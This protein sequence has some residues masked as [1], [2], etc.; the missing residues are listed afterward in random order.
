MWPAKTPQRITK[1]RMTR[2][3][4]ARRG[5][6]KRPRAYAHW[7]RAVRSRPDSYDSSESLSSGARSV[8]VPGSGRSC[9]PAGYMLSRRSTAGPP[10]VPGSGRCVSVKADAWVKETEDEVRDQ[11]EHHDHRRR[12]HQPRHDHVRLTTGERIDEVAAHSRKPVDRLRD[13]RAAEERAEVDRRERHQR[14]E[15]V[16]ERMLEDHAPLYKPLRASRSDV[17]GVDHLEHRGAHEAVVAG[18]ADDCERH[19]RQHEMLRAVEVEVE[20]AARVDGVE[21]AR[22]EDPDVPF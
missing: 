1:T 19:D 9:A 18:D 5:R 17:V 13:D 12:D 6:R 15:R 10:G 2:L 20:P 16:A 14:D 8:G 4:I 22:I 3:P 21:G 11:V 7:L